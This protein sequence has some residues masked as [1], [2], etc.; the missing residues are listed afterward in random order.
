MCGPA[1]E[2]EGGPSPDE[3]YDFGFI[4]I[5]FKQ[6]E[7]NLIKRESYPAPKIP[8]KIWMERA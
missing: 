5:N 2:G 3:Y 4:Q 7:N 1:Q 6:V 8:S